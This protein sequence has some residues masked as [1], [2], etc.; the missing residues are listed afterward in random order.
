MLKILDAIPYSVLGP[1]AVLLLLA[2]F[3]PMPHVLEKL[4]MLTDG[5][6]TKPLDVFDLF[7]HLLPT[8]LLGL[9]IFRRNRK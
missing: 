3:K 8:I 7:F 2:P 5:V 9:K 1:L 4:I 6:L